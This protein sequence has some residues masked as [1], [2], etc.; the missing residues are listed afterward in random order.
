MLWIST[1][2]YPLSVPGLGFPWLSFIDVG[3]RLSNDI[4]DIGRHAAG[5]PGWAEKAILA[6]GSTFILG[7]RAAELAILVSFSC[8]RDLVCFHSSF[9]NITI[10]VSLSGIQVLFYIRRC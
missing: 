8:E 2:N 3:L 4:V 10:S 7:G 5:K 6:F 1:L 9:T